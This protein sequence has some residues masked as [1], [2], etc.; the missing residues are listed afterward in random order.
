MLAC[1][2]SVIHNFFQYLQIIKHEV[3]IRK[4]DLKF[5]FQK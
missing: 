3:E 2:A 5:N 1:R 4:N